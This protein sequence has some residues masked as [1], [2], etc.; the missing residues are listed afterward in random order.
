MIRIGTLILSI[1]IILVALPIKMHFFALLGLAII[2]LGCA[3]IYPCVIHLTP[4][5][6]GEE[7]SQSLVGI[8]MA[9]AYLGSTFMPSVFGFIAQFISIS[10]FPVF[11]AIFT[12]LMGITLETLYKKVKK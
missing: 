8:Q 2:G 11:L 1:G 10:L 6:F 5:N 12:T 9:S 3:P 7:N 4:Q